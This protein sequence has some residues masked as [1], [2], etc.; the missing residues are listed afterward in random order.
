MRQN[1]SLESEYK[2]KKNRNSINSMHKKTGILIQNGNKIIVIRF[3]KKE[4]P[5]KN[6][7]LKECF[8]LR[9]EDYFLR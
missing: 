7:C 3:E 4:N 1:N 6:P 8:F 5:S 9:S 2:K